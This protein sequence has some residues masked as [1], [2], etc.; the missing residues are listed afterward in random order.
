M[1]RL[2]L[3]LLVLLPAACGFAPL[4][5]AATALDFAAVS[6]APIPDESGI[7]LRNAL[8]DRLHP[9]GPA[10]QTQWHLVLSP[11]E[12]ATVDLAITKSAA[13]TRAQMRL[14]TAMVLQ[15]AAGH[16]VLRRDLR[17][18]TSYNVLASE[19]TNRVSRDAARK[20]ALD[21]LAR[22]VEQQLALYFQAG[23]A[24]NASSPPAPGGAAVRPHPAPPPQVAPPQK[25]LYP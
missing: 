14:E 22:Q 4:Y 18:I 7:R 13:A 6:V 21:D 19:F 8:L 1:A 12:E 5:G 10:A 16:P 23:P 3:F 2:A 24:K 25:P 15:D 17:A 11:V 20:A 9:N